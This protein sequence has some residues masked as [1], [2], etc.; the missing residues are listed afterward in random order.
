M[1]A[2]GSKPNA[3]E[4]LAKSATPKQNSSGGHKAANGTSP[5]KKEVSP[6]GCSTRRRTCCAQASSLC[7]T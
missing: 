6:A 7:S 4:N 1:G 2:C 5:V 3:S